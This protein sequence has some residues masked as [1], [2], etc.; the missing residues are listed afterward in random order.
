[1][2][3][4]IRPDQLANSLNAILKRFS[5]ATEE[6]AD[7]ALR[8]VTIKLWGDVILSTPVDSGRAR[9]AWFITTGSPSRFRP[10]IIASAFA[11]LS[12]QGSLSS[13]GPAYIAA[14]T[15][16]GM[17]GKKWFLTNNLPYINILEF[18]GY[19][20]PVENG[21]WNKRKQVFEIRSNNGFSRQEPQGMVRINMVKFPRMLRRAFKNTVG[22]EF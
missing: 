18:G 11:R 15:A 8:A 19:P 22:K 17:F 14:N 4:T 20:Q 3:K 12:G 5:D 1:M 10:N 13:K 16:K 6:E 2:V 9:G 7:R 21:T